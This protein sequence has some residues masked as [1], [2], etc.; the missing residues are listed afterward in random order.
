MDEP[1]V[2]SHPEPLTITTSIG[3]VV[4]GAGEHTI[5][6]IL[7]RADAQLYLAKNGGRNTAFFEGTGKIDGSQ[8]DLS[9]SNERLAFEE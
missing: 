1:F 3:G 4:V 2:T 5:T 9:S 8:F 6:E 7:E